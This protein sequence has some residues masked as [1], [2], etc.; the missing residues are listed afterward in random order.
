MFVL[1][2]LD[3]I[4]V[5]SKSADEHAEHLQLVL[6][7]L[8]EHDHELHAKH[9][10]ILFNQPELNVL[11]HVVGC[12]GIKVDLKETAVARDWAVPQ[13][14][15]EMLGLT[16]YFGECVQGYAKLVGPLTNLP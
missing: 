6:Q 15:S 3:D 2:Y 16:N 10:K 1:V 5:F 12:E 9:S 13:S 8:C 14:V 7:C 4:L 11:S